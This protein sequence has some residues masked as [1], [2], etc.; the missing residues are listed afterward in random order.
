MLHKKVSAVYGPSA[1]YSLPQTPVFDP[2]YCPGRVCF[3][4][5]YP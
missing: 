5:Q 4:L 1:E 2:N 3:S